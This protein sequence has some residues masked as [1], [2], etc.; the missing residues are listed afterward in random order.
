M[1][2]MIDSN[3]LL[4]FQIVKSEYDYK[5]VWHKI[6]QKSRSKSTFYKDSFFLEVIKKRTNVQI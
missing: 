4:K 1:Y 3:E 2:I 6:S 5:L